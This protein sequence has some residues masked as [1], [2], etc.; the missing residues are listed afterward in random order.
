MKL[1]SVIISS[2]KS[3]WWNLELSQSKM[4]ANL[5]E[6]LVLINEIYRDDLCIGLFIAVTVYTITISDFL[7]LLQ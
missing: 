5:P 6:L 1:F 3:F 7:L 4:A 2:F